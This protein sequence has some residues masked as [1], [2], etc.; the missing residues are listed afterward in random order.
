MPSYDSSRA[1]LRLADRHMAVLAHLVDGENPPDE[2]WDS[3]VELQ[4]AALVGAEG[5]LSQVLAPLLGALAEP[6]VRVRVEVTGEHGPVDHGVVVGQEAV[7]SHDGSGEEES[8]YVPVEPTFLVWELARKVNLRKDRTAA[9]ERPVSRLETTM[10]TLDAAFTALA[11]PREDEAALLAA[12]R[13]AVQ[14]ADGGLTGVAL[15]LF[16]EVVASLDAHW[17]I[18][19]VWDGDHEGGRTAMVRA[20]AV[21]DAG[22]LGYWIREQPAEPV[23]PGAVG[24]DSPLVVVASDVG[25]IWDKIT[26]LLPDKADLRVDEPGTPNA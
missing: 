26:D 12:T 23:L 24:P 11:E 5:E 21:W 18:T 20:L 1:R 17:R 2:L 9:P 15:G 7:Y 3:L 19:T 6:M 14:E 16:V 4:A 10:A 8:E 25:E 13:A 22:P